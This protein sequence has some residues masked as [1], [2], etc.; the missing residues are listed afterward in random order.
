MS[1]KDIFIEQ[2][3]EKDIFKLPDGQDLYEGTEEELMMLLEE[4]V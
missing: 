2:L 4:M 1:N 3:I